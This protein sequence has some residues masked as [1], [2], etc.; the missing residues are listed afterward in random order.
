MRL[1]VLFVTSCCLWPHFTTA[2]TRPVAPGPVYRLNGLIPDCTKDRPCVL[3]AAS[4]DADG[5][6]FL[7][8]DPSLS[9][10]VVQADLPRFVKAIALPRD[11][12]YTAVYPY[13]KTLL[14]S[15]A[16]KGEASLVRMNETGRISESIRTDSTVRYF[17]PASRMDDVL[18]I[19]ANGG[20][21]GELYRGGP[22]QYGL[23]TFGM[24]ERLSEGRALVVDKPTGQLMIV[25]RQNG[26]IIRR[27]RLASPEI[28][29]LRARNEEY[30]VR[31]GT[32][33][34]DPKS[35]QFV[36]LVSAACPSRNGTYLL[37]SPVTKEWG[38][39]VVHLNQEGRTIEQ[40][41]CLLPVETGA[42]FSPSFVSWRD[43]YLYLSSHD[44]CVVRYRSE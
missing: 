15:R 18:W 41:S 5:I 10:F 17:V 21:I 13:N 1:S 4:A 22:K 34:A 9:S 28:S 27:L 42:L 40:L 2:A 20:N 37:L 30:Q 32:K 44:G 11:W 8:S 12:V 38:A 7:M 3:R 26:A 33:R 25:S 19:S 31:L 36:F 39:L 35:R 14:L 43:G 16:R 29:M 24:V 23:S 6:Y